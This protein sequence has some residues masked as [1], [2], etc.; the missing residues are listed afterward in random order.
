MHRHVSRR[1]AAVFLAASFIGG[2]FGLPNLDLILYHAGQQ[3]FPAHAAHVDAP[4]GCGTHAERC[5]LIVSAS[6]R[7]LELVNLGLTR[8][9]VNGITSRLQSDLPDIVLPT[10]HRALLHLSRAPPRPYR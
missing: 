3:G 1:L 2:G 6:V 10:A 4:G 7:Q 5:L 9:P 8:A